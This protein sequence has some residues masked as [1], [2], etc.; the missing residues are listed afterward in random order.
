[1]KEF[2]IAYSYRGQRRYEHIFAMSSDEAKEKFKRNHS[3]PIESC[4]LDQYSTDR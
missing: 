1:M 4:V 3:E 2:V